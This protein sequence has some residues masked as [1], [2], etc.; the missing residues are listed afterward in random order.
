MS[1]TSLHDVAQCPI[2]GQRAVADVVVQEQVKVQVS[3][4]VTATARV[5]DTWRGREVQGD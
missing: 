1:S 5:G 3:E 4:K 2:R